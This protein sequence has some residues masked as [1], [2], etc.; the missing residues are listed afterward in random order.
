M[1]RE[2]SGSTRLDCASSCLNPELIIFHRLPPAVSLFHLKQV[3]DKKKHKTSAIP[4]A[5]CPR[6]GT[7]RTTTFPQR[8][9]GQRASR[10]AP[11]G[12]SSGYGPLT[13]SRRLF[14]CALALLPE[15]QPELRL[16]FEKLF[17]G[18]SH[19]GDE[20]WP[21]SHPPHRQMSYANGVS[22]R[23]LKPGG[24]SCFSSPDFPCLDAGKP[25]PSLATP[26]KRKSHFDLHCN[27]LNGLIALQRLSWGHSTA[28]LGRATLPSSSFHPPANAWAVPSAAGSN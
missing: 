22:S 3:T 25:S 27:H 26:R 2:S 9:W 28:Y 13:G 11:P 7:A 16:L 15:R 24:R 12:P 23:S 17:C 10:D 19:G 18:R 20:A 21:R 8:P 1:L 14:R 6:C 5:G 4:R